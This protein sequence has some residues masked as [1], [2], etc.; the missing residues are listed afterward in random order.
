MT[1][2]TPQSGF[3]SLVAQAQSGSNLALEELLE[4]CRVY[5]LAIANRSLDSGVRAKVGA[6]DLVQETFLTA[7][8]VFEQFHGTSPEEL[9]AWLRQ[10]LLN[11]VTRTERSYLYTDKR[12]LR[13]EAI[14]LNHDQAICSAQP[15]PSQAAI[16]SEEL[17]RL[18]TAMS[19]L[20]PEQRMAVE[21]RSIQRQSFAKVGEQLDRTEEAARKLWARAIEKLAELL[22]E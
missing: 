14:I 7:H 8:R 17:A 13:R 12:S 10:I 22:N 6:S 21:L 11:R 1:L 5:L 18:Q 3:E 4:P 15:S 19:L 2:D 9:N 16:A 20:S